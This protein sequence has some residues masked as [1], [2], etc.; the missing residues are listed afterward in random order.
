MNPT[1]YA[2]NAHER[3]L[4]SEGQPPFPTPYK[5]KIVDDADKRLVLE[6]LLDELPQQFLVMWARENATRFQYLIDIGDKTLQEKIV[7]ETDLVLQQR[8]EGEVGAYAVRKAGFL[9]HS[10]SQKSVTDVSKYA[11]RVYAQALATAHMRGHALVSADYA[12]KV[13]N[14]LTQE[15]PSA[16]SKERSKQLELAQFWRKK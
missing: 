8:L 14:L 1:D 5:I 6:Q 3:A 11:A 7:S 9:A 2:W 13:V 16:A 12:V 15:N 4:Y 10:L